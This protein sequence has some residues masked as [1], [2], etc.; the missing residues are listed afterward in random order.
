MA[1]ARRG[2]YGF[3][4]FATG[5]LYALI[6]RLLLPAAWWG[7][8]RVEGLELVPKAGT[9]R[10]STALESAVSSRAPRSIGWPGRRSASSP[11]ASSRGAS[12]FEPAA[13]WGASRALC[14]QARVLLCAVEGT[15]DYVR[16]PKRPRVRLTVFEPEGGR[17]REGKDPGELAGR[18]LDELRRRVPP[19]L[20][21]RGHK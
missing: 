16:F 21:G 18:Y 11:K 3:T 8:V 10:A 17:P 14:P 15:T 19:A 20:A 2:K 12:G 7:R 9:S 6:S 13:V 1:E 5:L 4:G